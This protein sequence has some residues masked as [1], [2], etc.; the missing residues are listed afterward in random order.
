MSDSDDDTRALQL[1]RLE[2]KVDS[3]LEQLRED[4]ETMKE[5]FSDHE[6]RLRRL[7]EIGDP[8]QVLKRIENRLDDLEDH[9][10]KT[11]R[12]IHALPVG[13][14]IAFVI[15]VGGLISYVNGITP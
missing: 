3:I 11:D 10:A 12:W 2:V 13:T 14:V 4:R 9:S 1:A 8:K 15:A 6:F 5:R 7:E